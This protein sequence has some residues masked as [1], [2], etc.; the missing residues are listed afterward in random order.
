MPG[1]FDLPN[2]ID[3]LDLELD[4]DL[5]DFTLIGTNKD[6]DGGLGDLGD[7]QARVFRPRIDIRGITH[8]LTFANARAF[9][10]QID[11][12]EHART[13]AWIDGSFVFGD[14]IEALV[15]E[16]HMIPEEIYIS[17][18][19]LNQE[20]IDSLK[21]IL[22]LGTV[23]KLYIL[24]SAYFYSHE[25]Y[26]LVPYLY[27]ELDIGDILQVAFI[28]SHS[29]IIAI[30]TAR[31]NTLTIHGSSNLRSSNSIEQ[32]MIERDPEL[33]EYNAGIIREL[34]DT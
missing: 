7:P 31:G 3:D 18:L 32:I 10:Q 9:A 29:K 19:S 1:D 13:Y 6:D 5:S 26:D 8:H 34:T 27:Q 2:L 12:S 17:S 15:Y 25:K 24:L 16:R 28:N 33:Y 14:V 4:F 21:N 11:L 22:L 20:N 23:R 30:K